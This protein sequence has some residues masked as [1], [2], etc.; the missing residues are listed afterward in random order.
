[1]KHIRVLL[2]E[3]HFLARVALRAVL[4][5]A[6]QIC[7]VGEARDGEEG[8]AMYRSLRPDVVVLDLHLPRMNGF[9]VMSR[10]LAENAKTRIVILSNYQGRED[11]YRAVRAGA[12]SYLTKDASGD[13]LVAAVEYAYNGL[14]YMPRE[15]LD[16]VA[17]RVSAFELTTR[18][19]EVLASIANGRSN[20]EIAQ[21]LGIAEKTVR[22]HVSSVLSKM[23][24]RDRTQA[25]LYA[26]QH[27]FVH[28]D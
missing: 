11:I 10:L 2:V 15:A 12:M 17:E 20:R 27:G 16:R 13:Q 8:I 18:E 4:S 28:L 23:G 3:D 5:E 1:M 19:S 21:R 26:L 9:E 14:R 7:I 24:V 6:A 25:T 22:L